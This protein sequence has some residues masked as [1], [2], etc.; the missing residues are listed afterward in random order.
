MPSWQ[1][2]ALNM[3]LHWTI[4]RVMSGNGTVQ[5]TRRFIEGR[6][7]TR[8]P[9][10]VKVT[11]V[12][13]NAFRGEW[14]HTPESSDQRTLLYLPGGGFMLPASA[15]DGASSGGGGTPG[16]CGS[17]STCVPKTCASLGFAC[18]VFCPDR[19]ITAA[20]ASA[21]ILAGSPPALPR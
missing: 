19:E 10:G 7:R 8:L 3:V 5:E 12:H 16:V 1:T 17:G 13:A 4:K 2:K 18:G 21:A 9:P 11:P 20:P 14:I 6:G 15:Q